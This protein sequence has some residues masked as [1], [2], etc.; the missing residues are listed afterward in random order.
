MLGDVQSLVH[1]CCARQSLRLCALSSVK[2]PF[3]LWH[4]NTSVGKVC[5]V[6]SAG[7][8][9]ESALLLLENRLKRVWGKEGK[10]GVAPQ[11][12]FRVHS[13]TVSRGLKV[14]RQ[15]LTFNGASSSCICFEDSLKKECMVLK[16]IVVWILPNKRV[17]LLKSAKAGWVFAVVKKM[18]SATVCCSFNSRE[19]K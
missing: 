5:C 14:Q 3:L 2:I 13:V 10:E 12:C 19:Y 11:S 9:S 6:F 17:L 7:Q 8:R 16:K 18:V 1:V 15:H 4:V